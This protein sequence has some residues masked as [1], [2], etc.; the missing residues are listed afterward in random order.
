MKESLIQEMANQLSCIGERFSNDALNELIH[1]VKS[2]QNND[3]GFKN[4]DGSSDPYYS[5]FGFLIAYGLGLTAEL[6]RLKEFLLHRKKTLI[7][8]LTDEYALIIMDALLSQRKEKRWRRV[9]HLIRKFFFKKDRME[10]PYN[11]FLLLLALET[12][13]GRRKFIFLLIRKM[14]KKLDAGNWLPCSQLAALMVLKYELGISFDRESQLIPDYY[15]NESS[16]SIYPKTSPDMLSTA[17]V[18]FAMKHCG[19]DRRLYVPSSLRFIGSQ[20]SEGAFLPG[21]GDMTRDL[22]YTFYGMLALTSI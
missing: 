8:T 12:L 3:G 18:L 13:I 21:N 7:H 1:F 11:I 6:D 17:V 5:L 9:F 15:S 4:R 14:T 10:A 20:F 2:S 22:E 16:F 19:I